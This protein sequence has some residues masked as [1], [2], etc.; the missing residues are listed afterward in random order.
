MSGLELHAVSAG[1]GDQAVLQGLNLQVPQGRIVALLGANGA[2]KTTTLRAVFQA[3]RTT[4]Q[5]T[6][7]G[8]SLV[9]LPTEHI[10]NRGLAHVPQGRG[11]LSSLTVEENL[12]L[13]A[14]W[15]AP[16]QTVQA[17]LEAQWARFPSLAQRRHQQA[18]SLSGGEQ[19]QLALARALMRHPQFMA[20]DEPSLG[21]APKVVSQVMD[22]LAQLNDEQ[23]LTLLLVEQ[24][25]DL[26]LDLAHEA[27][28]LQ[29]GRVVAQGPAQAM[30]NDR[31]LHRAYL[32]G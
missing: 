6:W 8:Q 15:R 3:V 20:L 31:A 30:R 1:Y 21:L 25:A 13:G 19:Q 16:R 12:L 27:V 28:V 4:G 24:S 17:A 29:L 22:T 5:L 18:G 32:G 23:G 9:G 14:G 26:A 2:G 10:V 11:T 7:A